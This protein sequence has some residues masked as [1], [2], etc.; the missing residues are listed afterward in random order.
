MRHRN[1]RGDKNKEV[2]GT[3]FKIVVTRCHILRL[4][5]NKFDF[6]WGSAPDPA[7]G[8]HSAPRDPLTRFEG[9]LLLREGKGMRSKGREGE[10]EEMEERGKEGKG[11]GCVMALGDGRP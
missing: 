2:R 1:P 5:C 4:K 9:V 10:G 8:A 3:K 7:G 11:E 6:G